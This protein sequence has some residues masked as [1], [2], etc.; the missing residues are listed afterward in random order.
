M[1]YLTAGNVVFH[2]SAT[3]SRYLPIPSWLTGLGVI[4]TIA[5]SIAVAWDLAAISAAVLAGGGYLAYL[6]WYS[7]YGRRAAPALETGQPLPDFEVF[8]SEGVAVASRSLVGAPALVLFYRGNWCPFCVTQIREVA[9]AYR[10]LD[11]RGVKIVLIS[12]QNE[13]NSVELADQF[14][15]PMM[16]WTDRDNA[17]ARQLGIIDEHGLPV[18]LEVFGYDRDTVLPT[19]IMTDAIG[20]VFYSDQTDSYRVRPTPEDFIAAFDAHQR[21]LRPA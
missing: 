12:P 15:V 21:S 8:T 4:W 19:V 13:K 2:H 10:D 16:F 5:W 3:S 18:G 11:E 20:T 9:A 7:S 6:F 1:V 17:A 14:D